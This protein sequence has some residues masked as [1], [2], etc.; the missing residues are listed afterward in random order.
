MNV[1]FFE[2]LIVLMAGFLPFWNAWREPPIPSF[3][4]QWQAAM[5]F[6]GWLAL[7]K[8]KGSSQLRV[9]ELPLGAVGFVLLGVELVAQALLRMPLFPTGVLVPM[10]LLVLCVLLASETRKISDA[11]EQRRLL[12]AFAWGNVLGLAVNATSILLAHGK[13]ETPFVDL[14]APAWN[15]REIGLIAQPNH[16]GVFA[17]LCASG[18]MFLRSQRKLPN[19]AYVPGLAV[20]GLLCA[21][22]ASRAALAVAVAVWLMQCFSAAAGVRDGEGRRASWIGW[23]DLILG[24][25]VFGVMQIAW[26]AWSRGLGEGSSEQVGNALWAG[27]LQS[28]V[29]MLRDA[30]TLGWMKPWLGVGFGNFGGARLLELN[31]PL[32]EPNADNAHNLIAHLWAEFGILATLGVL[33]SLCATALGIVRSMIRGRCTGEA[34]FAVSWVLVLVAHSMVEYPLWSVYFLLPFA[35]MLGLVP[36]STIA[37]KRTAQS[38]RKVVALGTIGAMALIAL[39]GWDYR[40]SERLA[41]HVLDQIRSNAAGA[42]SVDPKEAMKIAD[43]TLFPASAEVMQARA[44]SV[45]NFIPQVK[46]EIAERAMRTLG[47]PETM[48]RYVALLVINGEERKAADFLEGVRRRSPLSMQDLMT[49]LQGY[50]IDN[51]ALKKFLVAQSAK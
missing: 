20:A 36:Q 16:L 24:G 13:I 8:W 12:C 10:F 47:H 30:W 34:T 38:S 44:L 18:M 46:L 21:S 14:R 2:Y 5:L 40:R 26:I 4:G 1:A 51:P 11:D 27:G 49:E 29:E 32:T 19:W 48:G 37:F 25:A 9:I 31:G 35:W 22:S 7:R 41:V 23:A 42:A 43:L 3:W 6:I 33:F 17:V 45:D 39:G 15:G 50:A 28:R